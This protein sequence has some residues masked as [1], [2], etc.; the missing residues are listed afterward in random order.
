MT[1]LIVRV[2][3]LKL[4]NL[5]VD[6][7]KLFAYSSKVGLPQGGGDEYHLTTLIVRIL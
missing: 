3:Y 2:L 5:K 1:T 6:F 4:H 7:K